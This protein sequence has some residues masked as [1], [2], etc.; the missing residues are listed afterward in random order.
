M[1]KII[2]LL[3]IIFILTGCATKVT[4]I[5]ANNNLASDAYSF[6]IP[7]STSRIYFLAGSCDA[8]L[9]KW[10]C[11][12]AGGIFLNGKYIGGLYKKDVMVADVKPGE[13]EIL[14]NYNE[15][16]QNKSFGIENVPFKM[17][18]NEK[19]FLIVRLSILPGGGAVGGLIGGALAPDRFVVEITDN[20]S[21]ILNKNVII[22]ITNLN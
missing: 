3:S 15:I 5:Q 9:K 8:L 7:E 11:A 17:K 22:P 1:K 13:Y 2:L 21:L 20:K 10:D 19:D 18:L 14:W 4:T 12:G 16:Y 6:K